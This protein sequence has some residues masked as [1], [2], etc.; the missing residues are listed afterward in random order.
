[1][2][3]KTPHLIQV[4]WT[5]NNQNIEVTFLGTWSFVSP[6]KPSKSQKLRFLTEAAVF[7]IIHRFWSV[8]TFLSEPS[9]GK[10]ENA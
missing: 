5:V 8:S 9:T 7:N 10:H 4:S 2:K 6:S 1:M 3:I